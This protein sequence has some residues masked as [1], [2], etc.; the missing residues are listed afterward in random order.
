MDGL[1]LYAALNCSSL[2]EKD[3]NGCNRLCGV[4]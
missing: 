2:D 1:M 3:N 4:W